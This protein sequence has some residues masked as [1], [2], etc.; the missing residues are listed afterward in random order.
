MPLLHSTSM[1]GTS[2]L[3]P[4]VGE[5][6][7]T[8]TRPHRITIMHTMASRV[9]NST[10]SCTARS[11]EACGLREFHIEIKPAI[12]HLG[13]FHPDTSAPAGSRPHPNTR[14]LRGTLLL[15]SASIHT[16]RSISPEELYQL[17]PHEKAH[18]RATKKRGGFS[19]STEQFDLTH[20]PW[21][22]GHPAD[23]P[24]PVLP[25]FDPSAR[26]MAILL[27]EGQ[28]IHRPDAR[29]LLPESVGLIPFIVHKSH[30][31]PATAKDRTL[32]RRQLEAN[33]S[34]PK[35]FTGYFL[36]PDLF[37]L[38]ARGSRL[39]LPSIPFHAAHW[40]Q[41][42]CLQFRLH[43]SSVMRVG[44]LQSLAAWRSLINPS[45]CRLPLCWGLT[46]LGLP[47]PHDLPTNAFFAIHKSPSMAPPRAGSSCSLRATSRWSCLRGPTF[48]QCSGGSYACSNH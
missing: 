12:K 11:A 6:R 35:G 48:K 3:S 34:S 8:R 41:P 47:M 32:W 2:I 18:V 43:L 17:A 39:Q 36:D 29:D 25:G 22:I 37:Q 28:W 4:L 14:F 21:P 31:Q 46:N 7:G 20:G 16:P 9:R 5:Q 45:P 30:C 23:A 24:R 1:P 42:A 13:H 33:Q 10:L 19:L 26:E 15:F 27:N 44:Q 38:I 40:R